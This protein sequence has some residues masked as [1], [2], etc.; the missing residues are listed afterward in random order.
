MSTIPLTIAIPTMRRWSF[1]REVLPRLLGVACVEAIVIC[2]ETGDDALEIWSSD[3]YD[4][5]RIHVYVNSERL[6]IFAT[7]RRCVEMAPTAWVPLKD[8]DNE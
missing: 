5:K 1:L 8:S 7:K 6:G 4:E 3:F 2:D